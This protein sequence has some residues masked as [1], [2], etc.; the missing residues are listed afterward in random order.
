MLVMKNIRVESLIEPLGLDEKIPRF[1]YIL[2]ASDSSQSQEGVYQVRRKIAVTR[3]GGKE[4]DVPVWDT[5]WVKTEESLLIP[6]AGSALEPKSRYEVQIEVEDNRGETYSGKT[7]WETG[8]M[9]SEWTG[10]WITYTYEETGEYHPAPMMRSDFSLTGKIAKARLY[11][12]SRGL[13]EFRINGQRVGQDYFTPGCTDYNNRIQY[14]VYDVNDLLKEGQNGMGVLLGDG[15]YR[16]D[17]SK[18]LSVYGEKLGLLMEL[19]VEYANGYKETIGSSTRFKS[20]PSFI[21]KADF[22]QGEIQDTTALDRVWSMA[23]FDDSQWKGTEEMDCGYKE[24]VHSLSTMVRK[25]EEITPVK[26]ITTPKGE[27]VLDM[28]QNMVGW[29]QIS[30]KGVKGQEVVLHHAEVLDQEGNFYIENLRAANQ[31]VRYTLNGEEQVLAPRFTFQGFRYLRISGWDG[32][33]LNDVKGMV[34]F[35]DMEA[36]G[37]FSCDNPLVNQLQKNIQWGQRGNFLDIP[38][39]CPQRDERLGWTGDAQAFIS[40]ACF[41]RK[42]DRF[43]YKWLADLASDQFSNGAVPHVIPNVLQDAHKKDAFLKLDGEYGSTGWGDAA[44]ICP[45]TVYLTYGDRGILEKQYPSMKGWADYGLSCVDEDLIWRKG[46]HFGD[47]LAKDW[48]QDLPTNFGATTHHLVSTAF[49]ANTLKLMEKT[50]GVLGNEKDKAFYSKKYDQVRRAFQNEFVSPAGRIGS[51]TQTSYVLALHFNLLDSPMKEK[52]LDRL[53]GDIQSRGN[54]LSTGFLGTPYLCHVL[55]EN[56]RNDVAYDLLLQESYPS[57]LYPVTK[58]ATTIWERWDGIREDGSFQDV[59]MNSY[60][61]Y[62]YGAI[63]D[64]LYKKAAGLTIDESA[65]GY[66]RFMVKPLLDNRMKE[67]ELSYQSGYGEI[68]INWQQKKDQF[69]IEI[70]VPPNSRGVYIDPHTEKEHDMVSGKH[71]FESRAA[72]DS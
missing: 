55:S 60:N 34:L 13:Y 72:V 27:T 40:T 49:L 9:G 63:G 46:F 71:S 22:Y 58:G 25:N 66:K 56:G 20:S 50:A 38:T 8:F 3:I 52:A 18:R 16:G 51:D 1:S 15:W 47:W 19:D 70:V 65:P 17:I 11:I 45:Y 23:G 24:V 41:N 32:V 48:P 26:I 64:W 5:D 4:K 37:E 2:E 14:Q 39:D 68:K 29:A 31:E 44:V 28:G 21:K 43:F 54:H 61:H 36:S 53:V 30:L 10:K 7:F 62:A 59:G 69:H 6:Y 12:T 57:W 33:T 35:S 42:A 67:V